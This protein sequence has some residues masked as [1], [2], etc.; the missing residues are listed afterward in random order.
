MV[1]LQSVRRPLSGSMKVEIWPIE[2]LIPYARNPRQI[3]QIAID[4]V[5]RS[6]QEFGFRQPI[7]VDTEGVII[8]GHVR[9]LAAQKLGLTNVPVNMATELTAAQVNAYRLADNR[10]NEEATWD[11]EALALELA[12]LKVDEFDLDLTGFNLDEME[13]VLA[14]NTV[15]FKDDDEAPAVPEFAVTEPGDLW[16]LGKHRLCCA[17]TLPRSSRLSA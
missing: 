12:N 9:R 14:D 4:K 10:T 17:A 15:G 11:T 13:E 6:I 5:A 8:V 7:V 3:P 16:T 2:R 1:N